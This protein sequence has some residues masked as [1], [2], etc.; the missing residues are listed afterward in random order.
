M[1][2][3]G[4][5]PDGSYVPCPS[6]DWTPAPDNRPGVAIHWPGTTHRNDCPTIP[7]LS[8]E[9]RAELQRKLEDIARAH[10]DAWRAARDMWIG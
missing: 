3:T 8:P 9:A 1:S 5:Q 2:E 4:W 6:C 7:R 10:R